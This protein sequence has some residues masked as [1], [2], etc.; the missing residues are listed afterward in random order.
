MDDLTR[1]L[2]YWPSEEV[3]LAVIGCAVAWLCPDWLW[4]VC[5]SVRVRQQEKRQQEESSKVKDRKRKREKYAE[6]VPSAPDGIL[7]DSLH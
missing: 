7:S 1:T 2:P 5:V 4:C 6:K 3:S